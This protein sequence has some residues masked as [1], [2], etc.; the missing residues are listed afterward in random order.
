MSVYCPMAQ[1]AHQSPGV[2]F[3][4]KDTVIIVVLKFQQRERMI[5]SAFG[6][7]FGEFIQ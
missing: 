1:L 3:F 2:F 7:D 4:D 6:D 5:S